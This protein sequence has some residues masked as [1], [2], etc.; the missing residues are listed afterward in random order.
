MN[1]YYVEAGKQAGPV[2]EAGLDALAAT[3][4]ITKDTLVWRE[5]MANW[6]AY[7]E[8]RPGGAGIARPASVPAV[9][10]GGT[11]EEEAVCAECAQM[12]PVSDTIRIGEARVCANCKPV[13][14]QKMREGVNVATAGAMNY[15]GFWVRFAAIFL[16]GLILK[17]ASVVIMLVLGLGVAAA[18]IGP[19]YTAEAGA[20]YFILLGTQLL[21][22]A[23]YEIIMV[24]KYGATLGKMACKI[25]VV[26][27][28]GSPV[29]YGTSVGRY[30]SKFV[31]SLICAIGYIMAAFDGE[32]RALHDRMCSTRVIYK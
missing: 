14:V 2:D 25:K 15:A 11:A 22:A 26:L 28:D 27:A 31:S 20:L 3:G 18:L 6:Q 8:A 12:F 23:V 24:G 9:G 21:I 13:F 30:F 4:K 10:A 1:W 16:D 7:G 19:R 17:A 32:K 5:G 29:P